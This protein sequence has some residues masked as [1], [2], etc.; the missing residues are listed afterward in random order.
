MP[1][2]GFAE[3]F[4]VKA[5]RDAGVPNHRIRPGVVAIKRRAGGIPH[6]LVSHLV[7]TDGAA[8]LLAELDDG[9]LDEAHTD[10][11]QFRK[12]VESQLKLISWADDGFASR[13]RLPQFEKAQVVVDPG[14]A[15]GHPLLR[16][17]AG[18]RVKDLVDSVRAGDSA[19]DVARGFGVPVKEVHEILREA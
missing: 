8:L 19:H 7:Y 4:V 12:A 5:A 10:Q 14:V 6:A 2:I 3:A 17:G 13:L 11:R 9:D 16:R 15:S 1:F 18:V